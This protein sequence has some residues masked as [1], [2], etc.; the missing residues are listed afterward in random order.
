MCGCNAHKNNISQ[1]N[2]SI[3]SMIPK[4][5][6]YKTN[7]NYVNNVVVTLD[8]SRQKILSFPGPRDVNS[9][10]SAVELGNGWLLDR[11]G[12]IN[13][14]SAFLSYTYEEY[15][16]LGN[17]RSISDL[18]DRIIPDARVIEIKVLPIN[19]NEAIK[20]PDLAKKYVQ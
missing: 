9:Q 17:I 16:K 11:Q 1:E 3:V 13:E 2:K 19:A 10:S 20:H 6:I 4:A 7:G 18:M 14:N 12:G 8:D 5:V 15:S